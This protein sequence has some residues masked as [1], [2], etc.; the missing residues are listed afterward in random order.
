MRRLICVVLW[1]AIVGL[2]AV[3]C[4]NK[5]AAVE[6]PEAVLERVG[7]QSELG[8]PETVEEPE[9]AQNSD[10]ATTI[11]DITIEVA[12]PAKINMDLLDEITAG[13]YTTKSFSIDEFF[14]DINFPVGIHEIER[15]YQVRHIGTQWSPRANVFRS[16]FVCG[17][18]IQFYINA[19][20]SKDEI[21]V[22]F[23]NTVSKENLHLIMFTEDRF[24]HVEKRMFTDVLDD[25]IR[26]S[27]RVEDLIEDLM[28]HDH[29]VYVRVFSED[30]IEIF[31]GEIRDGM[32]V[33]YS[34]NNGNN[35]GSSTIRR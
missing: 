16:V 18:E 30:N 5:K 27:E 31:E 17:N 15:I 32:G 24:V 12:S 14:S 25:Y 10:P 6:P 33:N 3:G 2:I 20:N 29:V 35:E 8:E 23:N 11:S 9:I 34:Y 7:V 19:S 21:E 13:D 4:G 22:N 28:K 1:V 26:Q